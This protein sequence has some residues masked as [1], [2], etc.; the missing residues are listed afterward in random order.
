MRRRKLFLALMAL[1]VVVV[2]WPARTREARI[3]PENCARI[4][5]GM[6]RAEVEAILGPPRD[7]TSTA[8]V[9]PIFTFVDEVWAVDGLALGVNFSPVGKV[10][11]TSTCH[12]SLGE[13][14]LFTNLYYRAMRQW[15]RWF[16]E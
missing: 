9:E 15:N 2:V 7:Y 10:T 1:A 8:N 12:R 16:P 4:Q 13:H 3:T 6:T 14:A 5:M 11:S